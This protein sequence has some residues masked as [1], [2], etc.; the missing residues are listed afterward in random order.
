M[1]KTKG[2]GSRFATDCP[3]SGSGAHLG[4]KIPISIFPAMRAACVFVYD[5]K[6]W[7]SN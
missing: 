4:L 1:V 3:G 7:A 2:E 6:S 5:L